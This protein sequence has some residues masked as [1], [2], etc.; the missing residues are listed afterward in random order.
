MNRD[1]NN[2]VKDDVV[3]FTGFEVEK[4]PV[5][6]DHTL[7]VVGA[8]DPKEVI[9]RVQKEAIEHV[10]LGANHSFNITLPFGTK[11]VFRR[12]TLFFNNE[13]DTVIIIGVSVRF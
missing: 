12:E 10:Y 5:H 6:G 7:F 1:Y 3:Y 8:Q 11:K 4:T 9:D 2:G 13:R